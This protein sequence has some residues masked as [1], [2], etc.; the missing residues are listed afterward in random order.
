MGAPARAEHGMTHNEGDAPGI[1]ILLAVYNGERHLEEQLASYGAQSHAHWSLV[2]SDDGSTDASAH[3]VSRFANAHPHHDIRQVAGP[4]QGFAR[5]FLSLLAEAPQ[6]VACVALS[7]QDD[8]WYPDRLARGLSALGA[9]S[10]QRPALYCA[11]TRICSEDLTPH[12]LSPEFP[13]RPDFRNAL[14]QSIGGGNTMMLNRAGLELARAAAAEAGDVVAQDWWLYQLVT[15]CGGVVINDPAPVLDY[16]QHA[17]NAIGANLSSR[18]QLARLWQLLN[19]RFRQWNAIN[20][21]ALSRS[22]HRFTPEARETLARFSRARQNGPVARLRALRQ[23]G[24]YRQHW[25]G[26]VALYLAAALG[27][28]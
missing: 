2:V 26:T 15:G 5:N 22:A 18:A 23:A 14:V 21:A 3:I 24:V 12:G 4:A 9:V 7:D 1:C 20:L 27:R 6:G 17:H 10:D 16:R 25:S 28:L 11:R 8:V 13:R 19:G